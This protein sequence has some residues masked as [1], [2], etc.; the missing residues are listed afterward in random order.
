MNLPYKFTYRDLS[1]QV[2]RPWKN[3]TASAEHVQHAW[4]VGVQVA[5]KQMYDDYAW[6]A[7]NWPRL[8]L[9]S[10]GS[11]EHEY[12]ITLTMFPEFSHRQLNREDAKYGGTDDQG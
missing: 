5:A 9:L 12:K 10:D 7:H 1:L 3:I 6:A 4:D 2:E 8:I 11:E